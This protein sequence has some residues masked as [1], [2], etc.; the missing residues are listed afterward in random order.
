M[1]NVLS[2]CELKKKMR[3][4]GTFVESLFTAL[5]VLTKTK[6]S[7]KGHSFIPVEK[8]IMVMHVIFL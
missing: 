3:K 6:L 8:V 2:C 1:S 5:L 7:Q 4:F